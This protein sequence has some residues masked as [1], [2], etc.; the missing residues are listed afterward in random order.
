MTDLTSLGYPPGYHLGFSALLWWIF[1]IVM[2]ILGIDLYLNA[3]KSDLINV[4]EMLRA[5]SLLYICVSIQFSLIQ[6]IVFFPNYFEQ[7]FIPQ[8]FLFSLSITYYF[9]VWEKNLTSIKRIPTISAGISNIVIL[10]GL[11]I[12]IFFPDLV[13]VLWETIVLSTFLL[14][15]IASVLYI[16][17]IYTFSSKVK[18]G[19]ITIVGGI[20]IGGMI[21]VLVGN[22]LENRPAVSILPDFITY[23]IPPIFFMLGYTMAFYGI[24]RLFTHISSYYAYT[25]K[26]AVHR[27]IIEKGNTIHYC[28]SCGIVYCELCFNQVIMKDGCWNCRKR[29]EPESEKKQLD[30]PILELKEA[31][32]PKKNLIKK[33]KQ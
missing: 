5:K 9:Y 17:L 1:I 18:G 19:K 7:V 31:E 21:L 26:C 10:I 33:G 14:V 2:I 11:I 4:K 13:D 32:E 23:Y 8:A 15:L 24:S 12:S 25:Q 27:G 20:W 3:K 28:S 22:F 6:V 16:Y 30:E 29:F